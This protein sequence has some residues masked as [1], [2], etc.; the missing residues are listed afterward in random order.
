MKWIKR[1]LAVMS[2]LTLLTVSRCFATT[3]VKTDTANKENDLYC[4]KY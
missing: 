1:I 3:L 2:F 4:K